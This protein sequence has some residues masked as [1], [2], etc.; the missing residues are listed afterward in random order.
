MA[1]PRARVDLPPDDLGG[2]IASAIPSDLLHVC[3]TVP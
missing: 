2:P 3:R 1:R